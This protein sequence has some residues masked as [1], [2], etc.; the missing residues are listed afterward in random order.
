MAQKNHATYDILKNSILS[1]PRMMGTPG[2]EETTQFITDFLTKCDMAPFTEEIEWSTASV[3]GRKLMFLI[4]GV[5]VCLINLFVRFTPPFN[6]IFSLILI[7][8]SIGSLVFFGK[9]LK[10]D[11]MNFLGKQA[12]GKNVICE[13]NPPAKSENSTIIYFTAHS[14][15]IASNMPKFYIKFII[16]M[17]LGFLLIIAL[18]I[19]TSIISLIIHYKSQLNSNLAIK[20]IDIIILVISI[21]VLLIIISNLFGKRINTSPGAI[22]NGS[23]SA[24]LLSLSE[25]FKHNAPQNIRMKFIWCTAE[26]WG[27]YGSKGYVKAHKDEIVANKDNSYVINV[28]MVGSELSYVG[29]AGFIRK[30]E[31]NSKLNDLIEETA[32]ENEIE[33]RRFKTLMG[34]RSDHAPF[35]KEKL[36]VCCFIAKKDM[37]VIH[38]KKDTIDLVKPEKLDDAVQLIIKVIE[39]L[40]NIY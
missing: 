13:I 2:E 21:L 26:E 37:K 30:K 25:H 8:I 1:R 3:K 31:L 22:D 20:I 4:M 23:G 5:F 35:K 39:K 32:L 14:D 10:N 15:S 33:A 29:K 36:E 28:D 40:D 17:L 19:A 27:L 34:G 24:I 12:K 7:P 38:S 18:T 9:A 11:K 6:G 16:G